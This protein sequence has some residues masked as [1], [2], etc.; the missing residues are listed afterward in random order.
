MCA[1]CNCNT[2]FSLTDSPGSAERVQCDPSTNATRT[3]SSKNELKPLVYF[4]FASPPPIAVP[5][6][7]VALGKY[8]V[9]RSLAVSSE[10]QQVTGYTALH[11][12]AA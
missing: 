6:R 5:D 12:Y 8:S 7:G 3:P 1:R 2:F 11:A 4:R 9:C 10:G